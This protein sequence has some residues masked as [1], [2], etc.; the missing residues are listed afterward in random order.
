MMLFLVICFTRIFFCLVSLLCFSFL[1][2][3]LAGFFEFCFLYGVYFD[4]FFE[5]CSFVVFLCLVIL[6]FVIWKCVLLW[7]VL[8]CSFVLCFCVVFFCVVFL[9]SRIL[10]FWFSCILEC[11]EI[12]YA[13]LVCNY[14]CLTHYNLTT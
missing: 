13:L 1:P 3:L 2:F 5:L 7:V 8:M 4:P 9:N 6:W 11:F 14:I 12:L 10:E